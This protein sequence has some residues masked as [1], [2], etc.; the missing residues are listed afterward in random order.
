MVP[1]A[2]ADIVGQE[3]AIQLLTQA[4]ALD[5]I[6]PAYLFVGTHGVGR[7]RVARAFLDLLVADPLDPPQHHPRRDNHP[8][9]LWI[10]P[11]YRI[12]GKLVTLSELAT[13][14]GK[15]PKARPQIRLAQIR[16]ITQFLSHAPWQASRL[17]VVLDQVET[18]GEAAANGLLKT[19]EEPG[20]A[21]L[22]LIAPS[23]E[24]L[25]PTLVSRCQRIPFD[26]L[27]PAQMEQVLTQV[28]QVEILE[29]PQILA[30]AQGSPGAAI[31][32][33][34]Q[35]Q[36]I[37]AGL[38]QACQVKP[39]SLQTCLEIARQL[40]S[41][42]DPNAQQWLLDYL[43]QYYWLQDRQ[44]YP[45]KVFERAKQCLQCYAQPR[46]VWEVTFLDLYEGRNQDAN[47]GIR[48]RSRDNIPDLE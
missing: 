30:M 28:G 14:G 4:M 12:Q 23:T 45:L 43:Q 3:Q 32:H 35:Y 34:Q 15:L 29:H 39:E 31:L 48:L 21:T 25:L 47:A 9:I 46:L 44:S 10:E 37:P 26:R 33:W 36:T 5:R 17:L 1:T 38:F 20:Q 24:T 41:E 6:A 18:L 22:I 40:D 11:T 13:Q 19:L 2:F 27:S 7:S 42:L 16:Q 8:D